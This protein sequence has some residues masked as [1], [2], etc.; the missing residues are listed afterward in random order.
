MR[1]KRRPTVGSGGVIITL[2]A[3]V[4]LLLRRLEVR[5]FSGYIVEEMCGLRKEEGVS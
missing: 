3:I 5:F 2:Q 4:V 1:W